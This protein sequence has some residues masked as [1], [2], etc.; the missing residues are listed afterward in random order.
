MKQ[1]EFKRYILIVCLAVFALESCDSQ[2]ST[3]I[4]FI[5]NS[6]T[7]INGGIDKQLKELAPSVDAECI[8][9]GGYTLEKHWTEG[10]AVQKIHEGK[11]DY[12]ILQEQ[13]QF[14]IINQKK[15][16][17]FVRKFDEEIQ[18]SGAKTILLMTWERPDSRELGVTTDNLAAAYIAVGKELGIKVAPAG[19][20]F[21]R[22]VR[23]KPELALYSQ[24]GH[25]TAEGTYLAACVLYKT[26][27]ENSPVGNPYS[28]RSIPTEM[29]V[30]L[31]GIAAEK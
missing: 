17:D 1:P 18:R 11:W 29:R 12:V 3:R 27:F 24:D 16:Y 6:Y 5:G 26:I 28:E 22:S 7:F 2:P 31:Q 25:P 8:A 4:L 19:L 10:N 14:P 9:A 13:S 30:Y 15:F 21:A 20:A 23:S